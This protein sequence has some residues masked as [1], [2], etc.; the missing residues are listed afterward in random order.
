MLWW[1]PPSRMS[2]QPWWPSAFICSTGMYSEASRS[3]SAM[4]VGHHAPRRPGARPPA[5]GRLHGTPQRAG[6]DD[7]DPLEGQVLGQVA[8]LVV[9]GLGELGIRR[10]LDVLDPDREGVADEQQLHGGLVST[11]CTTVD[12]GALI[13]SGPG[14]DRP[15]PPDASATMR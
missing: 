15:S 11:S 2:C 4:P 10:T 12:A 1:T 6:V 7:V 3:Y 14:R 8:G 9:A 13:G 5:A